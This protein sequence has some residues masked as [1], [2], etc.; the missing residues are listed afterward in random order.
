MAVFIRDKVKDADLRPYFRSLRRYPAL[1]REEEIELARRVRN[2]DAEAMERLINSNLRFVIS[3]VKKYRN[4]GLPM[5][6][7]ISEGNIGLIEAAKRF[8]ERKGYR[9]ISYAVWWIRQAVLLALSRKSRVVRPPSSSIDA[10]RKL[11]K[12]RNAVA[13]ELSREPSLDEME[14]RSDMRVGELEQLPGLLEGELSL[15]SPISEGGDVNLLELFSNGELRADEAV[16]SDELKEAVRRSLNEL[17]GR[18]ADILTSY[19]GIGDGRPKSLSEIGAKYG[20]SK[21]RVRQI[22]ER[23]LE[24]LRNG[25]NKDL[26]MSF[27]N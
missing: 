10:F 15:D 5:A 26:L 2:G 24:R 18:Q 25:R 16:I 20:I 12:E 14:D 19:F 21:E 4:R 7:L 23:A 1:S 22:K 13:Q 11:E 3:V 8:D 6:D 17:D 27:L 9:F